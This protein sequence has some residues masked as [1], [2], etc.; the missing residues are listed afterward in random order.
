LI[1]VN[2][3]RL[4]EFSISLLFTTSKHQRLAFT[5]V[6]PC[7][8]TR[9]PSGRLSGMLLEGKVRQ[10]Q[11]PSACQT[12]LG[13][14]CFDVKW[15]LCTR[16]YARC[17]ETTILLKITQ[18]VN[19]VNFVLFLL[20]DRG[21]CIGNITRR[22]NL[23]HRKFPTSTAARLPRFVCVKPNI[24]RYVLHKSPLV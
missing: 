1:L 6:S 20:V 15:E 24:E 21:F 7:S 13:R 17:S 10:R 23:R 14:N 11:T 5:L 16:C 12:P 18:S 22:R 2:V 9:L 8:G 3:T 19:T 4:G